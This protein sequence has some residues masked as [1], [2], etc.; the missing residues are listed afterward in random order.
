MKKKR[1]YLNWRIERTLFIL[2]LL[3][4]SVAHS[5]SLPKIPLYIHEKEIWVDVAKTPEER[6]HGLMGRKHLGKDEGMLFIFETEDYHGFWMKD[7]V[8]PLSIAFID[9][10]GRIVSIT[11]MRPQTLDSHVPPRPILYALEMNRG[12][13]SSHGIKTGDVVRFSK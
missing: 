5:Q 2:A 1:R 7:T 4:I 10:D 3:W 9:Q 8:I 12:W 11:D 13:F 6:N